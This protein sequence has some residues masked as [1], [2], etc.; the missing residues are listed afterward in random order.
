M[1]V[2]LEQA[3]CRPVR[4]RCLEN[5]TQCFQ[6]PETGYSA[7]LWHLPRT[8]QIS[9]GV[10]HETC[11][12]KNRHELVYQETSSQ[13]GDMFTKRLDPS[14]FEHALTLVN[15]VRPDGSNFKSLERA[16]CARARRPPPADDFNILVLKD[17]YQ[18]DYFNLFA[19]K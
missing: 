12:N 7:A 14:A 2:L 16:V 4:P 11:S 5:D 1:L 9:I 18:S 6:A 19:V 17:L 3:L 15:L 13:K 8:E 10:V